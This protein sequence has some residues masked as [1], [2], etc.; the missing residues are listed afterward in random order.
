ML[1]KYKNIKAV[2]K[3]GNCK[4]SIANNKSYLTLDILLALF[5]LAT[6]INEILKNGIIGI[7]WVILSGFS[8]YSGLQHYKKYKKAISTKQEDTNI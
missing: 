8:V 4:D 3:Y 7:T 1:I 6:G 2:N 5:F